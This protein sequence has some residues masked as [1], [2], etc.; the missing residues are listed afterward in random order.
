MFRF[1]LAYRT[2]DTLERVESTYV[3]VVP[4]RTRNANPPVLGSPFLFEW[5]ANR[6]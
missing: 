2:G 1:S 3:L 4:H 6:Q 5:D